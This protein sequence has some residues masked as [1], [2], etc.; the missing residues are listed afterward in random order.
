MFA[1]SGEA[2]LDNDRGRRDVGAGRAGA[3]E[4]RPP[5]AARTGTDPLRSGHFGDLQDRCQGHDR[6]ADPDQRQAHLQ[7]HARRV[8]L[9]ARGARDQA[10]PHARRLRRPRPRRYPRGHRLGHGQ[11][12]R[13]PAL[14]PQAHRGQ[15]AT[16]RR[17]SRTRAGHAARRLPGQRHVDLGTAEDRGRR[18]RRDRGPRA[19]RRDLD[20]LRQELG[21]P[22]QP[23]GAVQPGAGGGAARQRPARL[24]VAVRLRQ[25]PARPRPASAPTRSPTAPTAS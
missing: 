15:C 8:P 22:R 2:T 5:Q 16:A 19:R 14:E 13:R 4:R 1:A 24:R 20:G 17:R 7:G 21:R 11:R 10:R 6:P 23:L 25:R 18:H 3:R 12:S 9:V